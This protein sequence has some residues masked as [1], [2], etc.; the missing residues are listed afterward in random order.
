MH[1]RLVLIYAGYGDL[2]AATSVAAPPPLSPLPSPFRLLSYAFA[3][4]LATSCG[5]FFLV[6]ACVCV[7]DISSCPRGWTDVTSSSFYKSG[8]KKTSPMFRDPNP[9][10]VKL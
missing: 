8:V 6:L 9:Q 10:C 5:Q 1:S 4:R 2:A 3:L 7:V